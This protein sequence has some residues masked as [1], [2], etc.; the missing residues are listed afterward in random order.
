MIC[1]EVVPRTIESS[2]SSTF[3]SLNSERIALS[4]RRTDFLRC[5]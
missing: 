1:S 4:L 5:C 2:T 3:L